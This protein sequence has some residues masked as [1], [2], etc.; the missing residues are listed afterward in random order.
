MRSFRISIG[1]R[2]R[3]VALVVLQDHGDLVRVDLVGLEVLPHVLVALEVRVEHRLLRV[4]HEA[5]RIGALQHHPAGGVVEHLPGHGVE[6]DP[7]AHAADRPDLDRQEVEEERAVRLGGEREHLALVLDGQLLVD[8]LEIRGLAAQPGPVVDDLGRQLL[9][10]VVEE[11]HA[12]TGI[13]GPP[14]GA[15]KRGLLESV[16]IAVPREA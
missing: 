1:Q 2:V 9:G 8:P 13:L 5:H 4:G 11:H 10:R 3:Q 7:R 12:V 14:C 6:L 16:G 15:R